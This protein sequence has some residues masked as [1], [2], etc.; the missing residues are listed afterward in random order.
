MGKCFHLSDPTSE[1]LRNPLSEYST[2]IFNIKLSKPNSFFLQIILCFLQPLPSS[3]L[4][5]IIFRGKR[6]ILNLSPLDTHICV[7]DLSF[8]FFWRTPFV[9]GFTTL[10]HFPAQLSCQFFF[11][12]SFFLVSLILLIRLTVLPH[13]W[14]RLHKKHSRRLMWQQEQVAQGRKRTV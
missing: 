3:G 1:S 13:R 10:L 4:R 9:W 2:I 5:S 14:L 11:F 7:P 12:E 8:I 6:D